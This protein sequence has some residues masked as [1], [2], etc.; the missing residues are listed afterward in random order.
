M[1]V[2]ADINR[3]ILDKNRSVK[4]Y[5]AVQIIAARRQNI[6][7]LTTTCF[8]GCC[9][10][11]NLQPTITTKIAAQLLVKGNRSFHFVF[12]NISVIC[13]TDTVTVLPFSHQHHFIV[14]LHRHGKSRCIH[15]QPIALG[16]YCMKS[17]AAGIG[18]LFRII[19]TAPAI[20]GK[21]FCA[22]LCSGFDFCREQS[23]DILIGNRTIRTGGQDKYP[24]VRVKDFLCIH[25]AP[26]C[27]LGHTAQSADIGAGLSLRSRC[28]PTL[29]IM[30]MLTVQLLLDTAAFLAA[31]MAAQRRLRSFREH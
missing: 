25:K 31:Y 7:G 19:V 24:A 9:Y 15:C 22:A 28:I 21:G 13:A 5:I 20:Q 26:C 30:F 10:I 18:S 16:Q 1:S 8:F 14:Q 17:I 27:D 3:T 4:G 2:Q 29:V 6:I 11:V 12:A 23:Y